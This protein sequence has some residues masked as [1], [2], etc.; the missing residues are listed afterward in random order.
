MPS[1]AGLAEY[2]VEDYFRTFGSGPGIAG[3]THEVADHLRRRL[4]EIEHEIPRGTLLDVGCAIGHFLGHAQSRGWQAVGVE[5]S[6]WAAA[7]AERQHAVRVHN[8]RLEEASIPPGSVDAVHANHVLEHVPDPLSTLAAARTALRPDGLLVVEVPQERTF[9]LSDLVMARLHPEL[10]R[11]PDPSYHVVYFSAAGLRHALHRAGFE[12]VR[13]RNLRH[14][15][16][17]E[18]RKPLGVPL[19]RLLYR[20]ESLTGSAPSL[21]ATARRPAGPGLQ[22]R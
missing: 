19:K 1:A 6:S 5:P 17:L 15:Q 4:L 12:R 11:S 21:V 22:S 8:C 13:V 9:P 16:L 18:S 20:L 3:G 2:Y 14:H 7:E 10:Y